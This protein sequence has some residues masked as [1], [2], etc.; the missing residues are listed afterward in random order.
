MWHHTTRPL[1]FT[2]AIND[3]GIKYFSQQDAN[4]LLSALQDK[5]S[6]TIDWSGVSIHRTQHQLA[7]RKRFMLKFPCLIT[8]LPQH[9]PNAWTAPVYGQ[10]T[11]YATEDH[12]PFLKKMK[13]PEFKP[14]MVSFYMQGLLTP[15]SYLLLMKFRISNPNP[16]RKQPKLVNNSW[17]TYLPIL[18]Q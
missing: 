14:F 3:F 7:I 8:C 1:T 15:Q 2:L 12:S 10:K 6:I 5:Y 13:P 18:E 4:H 9:A 11:Q 17:I 16:Q